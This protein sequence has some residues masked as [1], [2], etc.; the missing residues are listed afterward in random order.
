MATI[1]SPGVGS[2][3]DVNGI[4][5]QLVA[6]ER[7][8]LQRIQQSATDLKTQVSAFGQVKSLV[9]TLRD[10]AAS[11]GSATLWRQTT[12]VSA[13]P[14]ALGVTSSGGAAAGS[15]N[16]QVTQLARAQ[17]L[18]ST[19]VTDA[20]AA[21]GSGTLRIAIGSYAS[22]SFVAKTGTT[23]VDIAIAPGTDSLQ[24]I[25]DQINASE[26][27]GVSATI[28]RDGTGARL[29]LRSRLTG[30][31]NA[32]RI[33]AL[34]AGG[35]A[36]TNGSGLGRLSY[37][38]S[39]GFGLTQAQA[40]RDA[41]ATIDSIPIT[42]ASNTLSE[43]LDGVTLTLQRETITPVSV[44]VASDTTAM[45][46]AV[47]SFVTA[48]NALN[49]YL[50]TQTRYDD[51]TKT[52]GALQG[53]STA[54]GLRS[55]FRGLLTAGSTASTAFSRLSDIGLETQ[56]DGSIALKGSKLDTALGRL[57]ELAR[58]FSS[59]DETSA[60]VTGFGVRF[61]QLA[62][63]ITGTEGPITTRNQGL[64]AA[65]KRNQTEQDRVNDRAQRI[66][67]RLLRQYSALDTQLSQLNGLNSYVTAQTAA[68]N[69]NSNFNR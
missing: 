29:S 3:L 54:L 46:A 4:V 30:E 16:V 35:A 49:S 40:A 41:L 14:V 17:A 32:L 26:S 56:R 8:P 36:I 31:E 20:A 38:P 28:V 65:I 13:D 12:A 22:G 67:E 45:R 7:A 19:A 25:R 51:A 47:T 2:G 68:L 15:Y 33:T 39:G 53:D 10:S 66:Q 69:R 27:A 59:A 64:Q 5:S 21:Y 48:Y 61:W 43:V 44:T 55:Q 1:S 11:L 57:P 60:D 34:D 63:R 42:S 37:P 62:D 50:V 9:S 24:A 52:A 58:I 18:T 23:A 6:L